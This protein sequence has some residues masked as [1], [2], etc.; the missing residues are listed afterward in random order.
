[1]ELAG[2]KVLIIGLG[3]SGVAAADLCL[4]RGAIVVAN[5]SAPA[6]ALSSA[7][8]RLEAKGARIVAGG[9]DSVD[10]S[11]AD[12]VVVSPGVP[13]LPIID[14]A[15][16]RGIEVIGEVELAS[17]LLTAPILA[18]GGT[19]GKSTTTTLAAAILESSGKVVFAGGNL[20][21]PLSRAVERRLDVAIVEVSSFQ[22]ERVRQF[23]PR[24]AV[25]LNVTDD[26]L[27]RYPSFAAYAAAKG[28]MFVQQTDDDVAVVP[29]G[30]NIV[31]REAER[32]GARVVTFGP[33][34]DVSVQGGFV[35]DSLRGRRYSTDGFRLSGAHNAL[36]LSAA[37][38]AAS[39]LGATEEGI[40]RAMETFRG[41]EH[42]TAF[43]AEYRKVRYYDD[44]K[45]TNVGATVAALR[46]LVEPKV[47]LIAGG[48]DKLGSYEPLAAELARKGRAIVVIG[49]AAERIAETAAKV[50]PVVRA[51]SMSEAVRAAAGEAEP[52]DAVLLSP[53][54]SSFDMFRDYKHRGEVFVESV[55]EMLAS[56]PSRAG[57]RSS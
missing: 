7:A 9:H 57:G 53:A 48:R 18:V 45:G 26:H 54:C 20:G 46:G 23:R 10:V 44:S 41:L 8:Q 30:D 43:V 32:G 50:I 35:V 16:A 12:L 22:M 52:G 21:E 29:K 27:D 14:R 17:R 13:P 19:N 4:D 55:L 31:L 5:D 1:M 6:S 34:G 11:R 38:A 51:G 2:K 25:L 56:D 15:K 37:V 33:G 49:E 40:G 24:V 36:N 3:A 47:V 28:N 42:R 39:E